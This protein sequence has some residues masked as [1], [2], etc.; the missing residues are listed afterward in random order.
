MAASPSTTAAGG[1]RR[2]F[3]GRRGRKGRPPFSHDNANSRIDWEKSLV[4]NAGIFNSISFQVVQAHS[5]SD[6]LKHL[7]ALAFVSAGYAHAIP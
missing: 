4:L 3:G 1:A 5:L 2:R 6:S 7:P